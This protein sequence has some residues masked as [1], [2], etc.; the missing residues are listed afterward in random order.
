MDLPRPTQ[1]PQEN[2]IANDMAK[3]GLTRR[4]EIFKL[5]ERA[6]QL[7]EA[8]RRTSSPMPWKPATITAAQACWFQQKAREADAAGNPIIVCHLPP[9][10]APLTA[11]QAQTEMIEARRLAAE[12]NRHIQECQRLIVRT[13]SLSFARSDRK[14][15]QTEAQAMALDQRE[16]AQAQRHRLRTVGTRAI[17]AY[18]AD[19][20][21]HR[22]LRCE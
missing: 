15:A 21:M 5:L 8:V 22:S 11:S 6:G 16:T 9:R 7:W 3:I 19:G 1:R 14:S 20:F 13:I 10:S 4:A 2:R 18:S 17:F 12:Y